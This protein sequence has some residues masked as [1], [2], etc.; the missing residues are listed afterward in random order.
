MPAPVTGRRPLPLRSSSLGAHRPGV[1]GERVLRVVVDHDVPAAPVVARGARHDLVHPGRL[2]VRAQPAG[3]GLR[4]ADVARGVQVAD[5]PVVE[6][7][8]LAHRVVEP[9]DTRRALRADVAGDP[10]D[11]LLALVALVTLRSLGPGGT[12]LTR[13]ALRAGEA[14]RA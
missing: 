9:A 1:D 6:V 2:L 11:P 10:L 5:V 7:L 13:V 14:L 3:D 4:P 12:R 8:D